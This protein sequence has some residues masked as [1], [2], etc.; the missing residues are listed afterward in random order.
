MTFF[1]G[2]FLCEYGFSGGWPSIFYILGSIG[3]LCSILWLLFSSRSPSENLFIKQSE[4]EYI[5]N[6]TKLIVGSNGP[7]SKQVSFELKYISV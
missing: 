6:E 7:Q 2:G 4:L 1:F 3:V 5:E